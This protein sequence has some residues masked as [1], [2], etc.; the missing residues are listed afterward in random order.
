MSL[1]IVWIIIWDCRKE[2][3]EGGRKEEMKRGRK[4]ERGKEEEFMFRVLKMSSVFD[5]SLC[6]FWKLIGGFVVRSLG[7][8]VILVVGD[9]RWLWWEGYWNIYNINV[10]KVEN[11]LS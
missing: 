8:G 3:K 5:S 7:V 2:G 11:I 6:C 9:R 10:N 1:R 4:E